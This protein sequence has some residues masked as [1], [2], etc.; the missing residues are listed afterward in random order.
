MYYEKPYAQVTAEEK[1]ENIKKD[2]IK[3]GMVQNKFS[4]NMVL[5]KKCQNLSV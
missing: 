3:L 2:R 1:I 4:L 5:P